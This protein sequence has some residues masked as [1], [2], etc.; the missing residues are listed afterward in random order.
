MVASAAAGQG[1]PQVQV[2]R[3]SDMC[4]TYDTKYATAPLHIPSP[5][6]FELQIWDMAEA[7]FASSNSLVPNSH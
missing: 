3:S 7:E 1:K 2:V 4:S 5:V 6:Y